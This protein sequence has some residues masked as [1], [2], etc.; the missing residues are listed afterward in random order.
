MP[1]NPPFKKVRKTEKGLALKR[2]FEEDWRTPSG[3]KDYSKGE[4]TFRP[5]KR[6]NSKT[7]ATWSELTPAEK[8]RAQREKNEKG[9][10]SRYKKKAARKEKRRKRKAA[11]KAKR[12]K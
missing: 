9:R 6:V 1:Y 11:R 5:T 2:W 3:E 10:V 4:N 8:R 7:A 12:N